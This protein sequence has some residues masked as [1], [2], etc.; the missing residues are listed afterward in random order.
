MVLWNPVT[1]GTACVLARAATNKLC[2]ALAASEAG[3]TARAN[4]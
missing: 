1:C 3:R 2:F 4:A